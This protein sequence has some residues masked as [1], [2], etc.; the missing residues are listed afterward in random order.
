MCP[1]E[2]AVAFELSRTWTVQNDAAS[3]RAAP[4]IA[5][6]EALVDGHRK[7]AAA[8]EARHDAQTPETV[9]ALRRKYAA[10]VLGRVSPWSLVER[11]AQ[12]ID[13]TDCKLFGA[14]QQLH[15]LQ[16]IDAMEAEGTA[17]DEWLLVALLHD[18]GKVLLL[19]DE[20][21]EN[22][23]CLNKP[24]SV[25]APGGGLANCVL[26]WNHDEFAYSRL[27]DYLPDGLAWLVRYHSIV[28]GT[29][30]PYMDARDREYMERYLRPFSR[31]DHRTKTPM[32]LPQR[33]IDDYRHIVERALPATIVV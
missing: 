10:P 28:P 17:T 24:V 14:S 5:P 3:R 16:I 19:T 26:Q 32:Y 18:I 2:V 11:L 9:A 23:V 12:C 31:Y 6:L 20:A 29:C 25:C 22:V 30:E 15:V 21:P 4:P 33:R 1:P 7:R 13:P 8:I 27:K